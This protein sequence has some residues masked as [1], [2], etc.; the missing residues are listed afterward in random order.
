M[1]TN[2]WQTRKIIK[3]SQRMI[4]KALKETK[5]KKIIHDGKYVLKHV[6]HQHIFDRV[7]ILIIFN[8]KLN[9]EVFIRHLIT[10]NA[11]LI[12]NLFYFDKELKNLKDIKKLNHFFSAMAIKTSDKSPINLEIEDIYYSDPNIGELS[13]IL[14]KIRLEKYYK[15]S[16]LIGRVFQSIGQ[17][18]EKTNLRTYYN[19]GFYFTLYYL[20]HRE[21]LARKKKNPTL[22][23]QLLSKD[24]L[25][26]KL[27]VM[28]HYID[29][30]TTLFPQ[31]FN[32]FIRTINYYIDQAY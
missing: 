29:A 6:L 24:L 12:S 26:L 27:N 16:H 11:I 21:T 10:S 25:I 3:I 8:E 1:K 30:V 19:F 31:T 20:L 22:H 7:L 28:E 4:I 18:N 13:T 2:S 9:P 5:D 32:T 17:H 15:L 14:N 23:D